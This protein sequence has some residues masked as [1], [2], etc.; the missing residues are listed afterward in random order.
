MR[1]SKW[2]A[3][4]ANQ[5]LYAGQFKTIDELLKAYQ[6]MQKM[7]RKAY[8][9]AAEWKR[10]L[11]RARTIDQIVYMLLTGKGKNEPPQATETPKAQ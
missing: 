7:A 9:Q 6:H 8:L 2:E 5:K 1:R 11:K 4:P 3:R 10:K